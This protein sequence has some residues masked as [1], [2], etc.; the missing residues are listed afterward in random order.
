MFKIINAT[1]IILGAYSIWFSLPNSQ[2][3]YMIYGIVLLICGIGLSF[4]KLWSKFLYYF[5]AFGTSALWLF[6]VCLQFINGKFPH[7]SFLESFISLVPGGLLL[8]FC[9]G[10]CLI[11]S[12]ELNET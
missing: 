4:K 8:I 3:L 1:L 11:V 7:N 2:W 5:L 9:V 6:V 12:N 10:S